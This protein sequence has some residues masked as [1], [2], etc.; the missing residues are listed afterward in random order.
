MS[1][2]FAAS[3]APGDLVRARR[4]IPLTITDH[5]TGGAGIRK[6]SKGLVRARTSSSLT[7]AFDT[8]GGMIEATIRTRDCELIR[9]S[10]D[11]Q[12]FMNFAQLKAAIRLGA[13]ITMALPILWYVIVYWTQTGSLDGIIESIV[14]S[15]L[16][17]A[18]EIPG[19]ILAHPAQTLIWLL[20][21]SLAA[22][23]AFGPGPRRR[24]RRRSWWGW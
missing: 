15:A 19:L 23:I 16:E 9:R 24:R 21:G 12:R 2:L 14:I 6:G 11:E 8:G 17:S 22:R 5:V 10:V 1:P 20:A 4:D 7:V 13:L 3:A 18:L